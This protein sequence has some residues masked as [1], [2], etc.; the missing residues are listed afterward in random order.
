[1]PQ[2]N[3]GSFELEALL[4]LVHILELFLGEALMR[5]MVDDEGGD[6]GVEDE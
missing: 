2:L 4:Y 3:W 1:M 5:V 6:V